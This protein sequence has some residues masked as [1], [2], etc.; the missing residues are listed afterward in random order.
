MDKAGNLYGTAS[1]G[2]K[3]GGGVVFELIHTALAYTYVDIYDFCSVKQGVF[4]LDGNNPLA[5]VVMDP[6]GNLYGTTSM[7]GVYGGF[8]AGVVFRLISGGPFKWHPQT[9]HVFCKDGVFA[10]VDGISPKA[11][12]ILDDQGNVY[13]TTEGGGAN[14]KGTVFQLA[15]GTWEPY[16]LYDF[17]SKSGCVDGANPRAPVAF[18]SNGFLYGTTFHGGIP[19][20]Y[21]GHGV[22]FTLVHSDKWHETTV[23]WFCMQ[24]G[25]ADGSN[26]QG[27]LV[28]DLRNNVYGTTYAGGAQ[29]SGV[30]FKLNQLWQPTILHPFC[31]QQSCNDG[32]QPAA[33]LIQDPQGYLYGTASARGANIAGT[34]FRYPANKKVGR[35]WPAIA[36]VW[37][38]WDSRHV[39]IR[40]F[41]KR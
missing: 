38:L 10:C 32:A 41:R 19:D 35:R 22:V 25:C 28:F 30:L 36:F 33:G 1:A 12:V 15:A 37:Q 4:C 39:S 9:L 29:G 40:R 18:N 13:G 17:C 24:Q 2:G 8:G 14:G 6:A 5:N 34:V 16:I 20:A 26:P 11:G 23:Y 21:G 7:G 27:G 31:G 3:Y